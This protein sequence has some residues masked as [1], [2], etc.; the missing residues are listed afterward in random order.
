M[1]NVLLEYLLMKPGLYQYEMADFLEDTFGIRVNTYDISQAMGSVKWSKK[2]T[3][4][5]SK[6]RNPDLRDYYLHNLSEFQSYY[7]IYVP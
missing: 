5:V 1:L 4:Q 2:V 3:F 7:L 6:E